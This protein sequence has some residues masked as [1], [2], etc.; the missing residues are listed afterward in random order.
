M[1]L[2]G[3]IENPGRGLPFEKRNPR[4]LIQP[5]RERKSKNLGWAS[6]NSSKLVEH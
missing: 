4:G 1:P 6:P 5:V 2:V 3:H